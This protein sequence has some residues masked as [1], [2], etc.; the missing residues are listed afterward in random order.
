M[1]GAPISA[2]GREEGFHLPEE[3][4]PGHDVC[5]LGQLGKSAESRFGKFDGVHGGCSQ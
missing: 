5:G 3:F 4:F 1:S 2:V